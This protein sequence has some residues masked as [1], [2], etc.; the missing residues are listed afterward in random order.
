MPSPSFIGVTMKEI[1]KMKL[2]LLYHPFSLE[3]NTWLKIRKALKDFNESEY[4]KDPKPLEHLRS[5]FKQSYSDLALVPP[6]YCDH[7]INISIGR[8]F[9]GNTGITILDEATVSIGNDVFM[10]PHVS[11]Y[12]PIHPL[13]API[14]NKD[15]ELAKPITIEDSVWIAGD[16]VVNAGV[17]IGKGSVIGSGSVVTKSIPPGVFAAGNPCKVIRKIE[18]EDII[19][20]EKMYKESNH[21]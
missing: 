16:V 19:Y 1:D 9:Q 12:T 3:E 14:R 18:D 8:H 20:W 7:G 10:G 4:W 21:E 5:F 17:T 2:G 11:L 15:V 13:W 6:F